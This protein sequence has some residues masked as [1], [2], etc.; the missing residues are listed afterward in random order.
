MS[1]FLKKVFFTCA[2][3]IS[4]VFFINPGFSEEKP[5]PLKLEY[6]SFLK[7][8]GKD[9]IEGSIFQT[10]AIKYVEEKGVNTPGV[11]LASSKDFNKTWLGFNL[12]VPK[13]K[14]KD[15][16]GKALLLRFYVKRLQGAGNIGA[17]MRNFQQQ[18]PNWK[19]I[20]TTSRRGAYE[21]KGNDWMPIEMK[22]RIPD[23]Q[24]VD[25]VDF[26]IGM[27]NPVGLVEFMIDE[28]V[29]ETV[30]LKDVK[31]ESSLMYYSDRNGKKPLELVKDG[32]P[33]AVIVT[34]AKPTECV[35]YAVQ[36]LNAHIELCTGTKLPVVTEDKKNE[37]PALYIGKT[38]LSERFC[39]SPDM[40]P[41]DSW[42]VR[43]IDNAVIIS[44]GDNKFN[45]NPRSKE[46]VPFGTLYAAYEFLERQLKVR[47]YWP[48]KLGTVT[49]QNKNIIVENIN[50]EG[51]P[52]YNTR[53]AFY[54]RPDDKDISNDE[55]T[56]WWRRMRRGSIGG[57]PIG[58][59]SFNKWPER[60]AKE[61]PEYFAIQPDGKPLLHSNSGG[62][63][64]CFSNPDVLKQT[65]QDK[66]D[67]F[68]KTKW[69][70]FSPVMPGDSDDL[71]YCRCDKCKSQ[72]KAGKRSEFRSNP[73]WGFV[74]KAAAE[75]RKTHPK[76][77]ITCC[78]YGGYKEVP[79]FPLESNIAVT[80]CLFHPE[81]YWDDKGKKE[82]VR[83]LDAWEK[84]GASMY[85]WD[86]VNNPRYY[87]GTYGA[88][89]IYPHAIKEFYMLDYGRAK[90]H[91]IELSDIN[92]KGEGVKKWADWIYDS[93]NVYV[94]MRLLWNIN[95]DVDT[96]LNEFYEGFYG[97][98]AAPWM[99]KFYEEME[100]AYEN[101]NTKGG[102]DFKWD[103]ET[104]WM[105][106]YPPAF[107][108]KVMG[109]LRKAAEVSKGQEPYSARV[110]KTLDAYLPFEANGKVFNKADSKN[111][112]ILK[113]PLTQNPPEMN[114]TL[115][116]PCW[117]NAV[118]SGNFVD[119][120]NAYN[121]LAK[122]EMFLLRDDKNLYIGVRSSFPPGSKLRLDLPENSIDRYVWDNESCE[123]FFSQG[124]KKY[125]LMLGPGNI[126][127]DIRQPDMKQP[128]N[129][130]QMI[131][132]NCKDIKYITK[133]KENEWTAEL[134]IPLSSLEL[135][136]PA[137]ANPWRV[138]FC[139]NYYYFKE[140]VKDFQHELST[141][142]PTYGSFHNVE[143]FGK[144]VF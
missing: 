139:R 77:F 45:L 27:E 133:L 54:D 122:T 118:S 98:A 28:P 82:Y 51:A 134:A 102:P 5:A 4:M 17:T 96:I 136:T 76:Q 40:L 123:F 85:M 112:R 47:W 10:D 121:L 33:L 22:C 74:N 111:D 138:N 69:K 90:G 129:L 81:M 43:R 114:G 72:V 101:P 34:E 94:S 48:G 16:K 15:F 68:D 144:L 95:Q 19:L 67:E 18:K 30:E 88:P 108:E 61:H 41:P 32:K 128:F 21:L 2:S 132:W 143:R 99:K 7:D 52:S 12:K 75:V 80:L 57:S 70:M 62:G 116:S 50:W 59:H 23:M 71:F 46:L 124:D 84:T 89:A 49:P 3:L 126:Y 66:R 135:S 93:P 24:E 140:G 137:E 119:S 117:K 26:Q 105:K 20:S 131:K 36:E 115:D 73:V 141:W 1:G 127:A 55:N 58:M 63:H 107:I 130:E 6:K 13:D 104:C 35:K 65:V 11:L 120:F 8:A 60:F 103:W 53:F 78:A 42:I 9:P 37:S 87:K 97:S 92:N 56:I 39:V 29:L 91:V 44:G 125:Q 110:Q 113:V 86:Y 142:S 100:L 64:V 25:L 79:D 83:L 31:Y 106:T 109:Y 14:I 38:A